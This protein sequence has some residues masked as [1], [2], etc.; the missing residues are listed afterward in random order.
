MVTGHLEP[1]D[2]NLMALVGAKQVVSF[3]RTSR[4]KRLV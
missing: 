4:A 3:P 1:H 2:I